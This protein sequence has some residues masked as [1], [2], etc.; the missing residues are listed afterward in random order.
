MI[1]FQKAFEFLGKYKDGA[2]LGAGGSLVF[3]VF[4]LHGDVTLEIEKAEARS[5]KYADDKFEKTQI[6]V[7]HLK[8]GQTK[9]LE[10]LKIIDKR[11]YELNKRK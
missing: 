6:E 8:D 3:I 4:Y 9:I 1:L 2:K 10:A 11:V 5:V 7:G